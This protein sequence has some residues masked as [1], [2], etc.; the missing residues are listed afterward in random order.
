[1]QLPKWHP[2]LGCEQSRIKGRGFWGNF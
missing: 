1:M 2:A